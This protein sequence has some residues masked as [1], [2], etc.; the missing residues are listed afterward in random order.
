M[1]VIPVFFFMAEFC[2]CDVIP[3]DI[4]FFLSFS[5]FLD[6]ARSILPHCLKCHC[7]FIIELFFFFF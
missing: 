2:T 3:S 4:D 7:M 5:I 6:N 1:I